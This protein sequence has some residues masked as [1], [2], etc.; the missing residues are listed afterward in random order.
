MTKG[1][2]I[3][4][5]FSGF[6]LPAYPLSSVPE[7]VVFPYLT[8]PLIVDAGIGNTTT[9]PV[10]LWFYTE[11]EAIP[12]AKAA[13][14]SEEIGY[15][16]KVLYFTGGAVWIRRGTPWCRSERDETAANIKLRTLNVELEWISTN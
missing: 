8:Y 15:G 5:F 11:S 4:E 12:N 1:K 2:A 6:G 7:D 3:Q 14:I 13:Q 16:G 9:I 10:S